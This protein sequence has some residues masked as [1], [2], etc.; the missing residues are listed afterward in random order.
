MVAASWPVT[1]ERRLAA[2]PVGAPR[3]DLEAQFRIEVRD[4]AYDGRLA[5]AGAAR[6]DEHLLRERALD[7]RP[8]IFGRHAALERAPGEVAQALLCRGAGRPLSP[9]GG[10]EA[11]LVARCADERGET[12][13]DLAFRG[14]KWTRID[15]FALGRSEILGHVR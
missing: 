11:R 15:A 1:S 10:L 6:N 3:M 13:G 2:R 8:L 4:G 12:A 14:V 7:G 5:G 9:H